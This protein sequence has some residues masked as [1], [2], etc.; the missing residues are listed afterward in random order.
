LLLYGYI[1]HCYRIGMDIFTLADIAAEAQKQIQQELDYIEPVIAVRQHMRQSGIPADV[2]TI[3]CNRAQRRLVVIVHDQQPD[4]VMHR[5]D[6]L[7]SD[8]D[9]DLEPLQ[10]ELID[11]AFFVSWM[12][13]EL[14]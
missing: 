7:K 2:L 4:T 8:E 1:S 3:E 14:A 12:R 5:S 13:Q 11:T 9:G 10:K 6:C